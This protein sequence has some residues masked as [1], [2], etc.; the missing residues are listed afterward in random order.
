[1]P[2]DGR[3][4]ERKSDLEAKLDEFG[5]DPSQVGSQSAGQSG[6]SQGL[7]SVEDASDESVEELADSDQA[8]ESASLEGIEDAADHPERPTIP[9]RNM[10]IRMTCHPSEAMSHETPGCI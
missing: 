10:A 6:G 4:P 7:S 5:T 3:S 8:L 1:M 2:T 9:I